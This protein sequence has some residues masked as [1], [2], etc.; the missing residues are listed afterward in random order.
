MI[1]KIFIFIFI[2]IFSYN[3]YSKSIKKGLLNDILKKYNISIIHTHFGKKTI[4]YAVFSKIF[5]NRN[6]KVI[7]HWR[8]T[9]QEVILKNM[10]E[11]ISF[12][13]KI[14]NVMSP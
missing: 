3:L 1:K 13:R 11:K 8:S 5:L 12:K 14:K 2:F 9:P 4:L 6:L 7:R 10:K